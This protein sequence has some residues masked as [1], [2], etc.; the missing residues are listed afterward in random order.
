MKRLAQLAFLFLLFA[1]GAG[2]PLYA[3]GYRFD[4]QVAQELLT[5]QINGTTNVLVV[6][7][8]PQIA[9]C[10]FPANAVPCTNKATTY[11]SVTLGTPCSTS[12]QITLTGSSSCVASPDAQANWGVWIP[13]GQYAYTIT[14]SSANFGPFV[15]NFGVPSGT[16]L[17]LGTITS[18]SAN[19]AASGYFRLANTDFIKWRNAANNGDCLL[20]DNGAA[21]GNIPADL[22][23]SQC[24]YTAPYYVS[25]SSN[26]VA[27]S[28][29]FRMNSTDALSW[30]NNANSADIT[31]SKNAS[32]Q[33]VFGAPLLT[34]TL[35][36][37]INGTGLQ[38]FTVTPGAGTCPT[39]ASIG[40]LCT[41]GNITLPVAY[42]DTN[43][44]LSC[45]V[46]S[47]TN[48]AIVETYTKSNTTFTVTIA[49]LT[50][51]AANFG[52]FDCMA[53]HN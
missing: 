46:L 51:A 3:Q 53:V 9:F 45:T 5:F 8:T 47:P 1:A 36:G 52:S 34:P 22:I 30:R 13:Q 7:S 15:V 35:T 32:D 27:L 44:R 14:T 42:S 18:S 4:N 17:T 49:A 24:G 40:A 48:V 16:A 23:V 20:A 25:N 31:I 19:P 28:G 11:T 6:P 39:V 10:N 2:A 50:A 33:F 12:T 21:Q 26:A 41:T 29:V 37:V 38:L 43:Y